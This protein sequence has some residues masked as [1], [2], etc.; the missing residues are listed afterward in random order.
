MG[1]GQC[2]VCVLAKVS[3]QFQCQIQIIF[4]WIIGMV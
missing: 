3:P 2:N 1:G 4:I